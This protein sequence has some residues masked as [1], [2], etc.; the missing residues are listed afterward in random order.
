[1]VIFSWFF[2]PYTQSLRGTTNKIAIW[3][4]Q[5]SIGK[6]TD[7]VSAMQEKG[8]WWKGSV[9]GSA[10][11]VKLGPGP[12]RTIMISTR[13]FSLSL[14]LSMFCITLYFISIV[15]FLA[16]FLMLLFVC[17][18]CCCLF[19]YLFFLPFFDALLKSPYVRP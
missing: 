7:I 12:T 9:I 6:H 10:D 5:W 15:L 19:I 4:T 8:C 16:V 17:L 2:F 11:D 14:L 1:M 3:I 18:C 13:F